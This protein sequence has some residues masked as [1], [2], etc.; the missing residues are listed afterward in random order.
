MQHSSCLPSSKTKVENKNFTG[1]SA[2]VSYAF[3]NALAKTGVAL[4]KVAK[5]ENQYDIAIFWM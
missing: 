2:W 5:T 1:C 4:S 3:I